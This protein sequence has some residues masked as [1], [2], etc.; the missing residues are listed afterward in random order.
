MHLSS[1]Q[2]SPGTSSF[3]FEN[4]SDLKKNDCHPATTLE[5]SSTLPQVYIGIDGDNKPTISLGREAPPIK[6]LVL[7]GGGAKGV[8]FPYF[9]KI[10]NDQMDL[11]RNLEEV[12]GSS[13]GACMAFLI[14][15]GISLENVKKLVNNL[16]M[17]EELI[18][19]AKVGAT[20]HIKLGNGLL[21]AMQLR[22]TLNNESKKPAIEFYENFIKNDEKRINQIEEES[23]EDFLTRAEAGF[24][25]GL[26]FRD[27]K[28]LHA[29]NPEQ[30]KRLNVTAY[31][32]GIQ[33]PVYLNAEKTPDVNCFEGVVASMSIPMV[34][35][36]VKLDLKDGQGVRRLVD[37]GAGTN[38]PLEIFSTREDYKPEENMVLLFN[39]K[40]AVYRIQHDPAHEFMKEGILEWIIKKVCSIANYIFCGLFK[41][42]DTTIHTIRAHRPKTSWFKKKG[43]EY[44]G[45]ANFDQR[46]IKD[47]EKVYNIGPNGLVVPHGNLGTLDFKAGKNEPKR[48]DAAIKQA[49]AAANLYA[50]LRGR[51]HLIQHDYATIED[52]IE[53]LTVD[54]LRALY[55]IADE[56]I[57]TADAVIS[58][59]SSSEQSQRAEFEKQ[60]YESIKVMFDKNGIPLEIGK[61]ISRL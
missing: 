50:K 5:Q 18:G 2:Y 40:G 44:I 26:T 28:I 8:V 59:I 53:S 35:K 45:V 37:G 3:N 31:D 14:A 38:V 7:Q 11:L 51:D 41:N 47:A 60:F 49:E 54:E 33:Q 32:K 4:N 10:L 58:G 25:N 17:F 22:A 34:M 30:F 56:K 19:V 12:A 16:D 43:A 21:S 42:I 29:L 48:V 52:A 20:E 15:A 9:I 36:S 46:G 23:R 27:L 1:S 61:R 24:P 39:R 55:L 57:N 13:A 6:H